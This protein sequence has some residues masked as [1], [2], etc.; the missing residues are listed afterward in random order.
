MMEAVVS[1]QSTFFFFFF[2][3][4]TK[5]DGI[6]LLCYISDYV[7]RNVGFETLPQNRCG[8]KDSWV[9]VVEIRDLVKVWVNREQN[10]FEW[11]TY[12]VWETRSLQASPVWVL[13]FFSVSCFGQL[14]DFFSSTYYVFLLKNF[15]YLSTHF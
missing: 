7:K 5:N 12:C 6:Y 3:F 14:T 1:T 13:D 9:F 2:F 4:D 11:V 15:A 10:H 8:V